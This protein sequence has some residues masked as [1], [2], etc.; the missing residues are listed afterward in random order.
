MKAKDIMTQHVAAV[1]PDT[2]VVTI[3]RLMVDLGISAVPVVDEAGAVLGIVSEGDLMRRK[4]LGTGK[5]HSWWLSFLTSAEELAEE[6]IRSHG[7]H[8]RDVMTSPAITVTV[9]AAVTAVCDLLDEKHIKR[10]PVVENGR[11][12]GIVSRRDFVRLLAERDT[13]EVERDDSAIRNTLDQRVK[14]QPWAPKTSVN[15]QVENGVVELWGFVHAD[16]QR[17]ALRVMAET[18]PGVR[19]VRNH[20]K[21]Q[22][23]AGLAV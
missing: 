12:V 16:V 6:Y 14:A 22:V 20:L 21:V 9:D 18:T 19:E 23:T 10:V 17:D 7:T 11:L 2:E 5:R 8:A 4:E 3:A 1:G 15:I 13:G